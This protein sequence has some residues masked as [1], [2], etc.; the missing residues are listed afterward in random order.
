MNKEGWN[1]LLWLA[2]HH[3][4]SEISPFTAYFRQ[5]AGSEAL[6]AS[7]YSDAAKAHQQCTMH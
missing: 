6:A 5:G 3:G 1:G 7:E 2:E 4:N